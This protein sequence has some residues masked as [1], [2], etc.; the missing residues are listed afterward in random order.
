MIKNIF[1]KYIFLVAVLFSLNSCKDFFGDVNVDPNAANSAPPSTLLPTIQARVAYTYWG[2]FSRYSS[3]FTQHIKGADRQF[4][5]YQ[6]YTFIPDD[7]TTAWGN[8]YE[9]SLMDIQELK[10]TAD[11]SGLNMYGGVARALEAYVLLMVADFWGNA[12]YS[13]A[14]K[15]D[16]VL[17][18]KYDTQEQ[19]YTT[20]FTL[21]TEAR[22]KLSGDLGSQKPTAGIDIIYSGDAAKWTKFCNVLAARAYLHLGKKDAANYTKALAELSKGGFANNTES[23]GFKFLAETT[24]NAPWFQYLDQRGD[25]A[26]G[27]GYTD[28]MTS[29]KD[30]RAAATS[31]GAEFTNKHPIFV[32]DQKTVLLGYTEQKFIEAELLARTGGDAAKTKTA[33]EDGIKSSMA[34]AAITDTT[35]IADYLKNA[36]VNPAV[37]TIDAIMTQK[38]L[39]LFTNPEVLNDWRRTG[40]PALTPHKGTDIPRRFLYPQT[41]FDLNGNTP[42]GLTIFS[43]VGW[44]N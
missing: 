40:L 9:G 10:K 34:E 4:A 3:I 22:T 5:A 15:G 36:A 6:N 38:Y 25:V 33:F 14:F 21:L 11:A 27:V 44:D 28:I 20:V 43:K 37:T 23:A 18:P 8:C 16:L 13:D 17:Q 41:E 12:P 39:A 30:P 1:S 42:K 29:L 32:P 31:Y 35:A 7:F 24:G 2:D 26:N 19:L